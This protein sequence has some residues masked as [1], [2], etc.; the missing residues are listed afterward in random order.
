MSSGSSYQSYSP[1]S[2]IFEIDKIKSIRECLFQYRRNSRLFLK[3]IKRYQP[4]GVTLVD[5]SAMITTTHFSKIFGKSA[6]RYFKLLK[7]AKYAVSREGKVLLTDKFKN[8]ESEEFSLELRPVLEKKIHAVLQGLLWREVELRSIEGCIHICELF[9][10]I[11]A[12]RKKEIVKENTVGFRVGNII[13]YVDFFSKPTFE[14]IELIQL[15]LHLLHQEKMQN[16]FN[17]ISSFSTEK[18]LWYK[19]SDKKS[20]FF[21][22]LSN[23]IIDSVGILDLSE[24]QVQ[25]SSGSGD[26]A[27]ATGTL[28]SQFSHTGVSDKT[29]YSLTYEL[30]TAINDKFEYAFRDIQVMTNRE[31]GEAVI[32]NLYFKSRT[33]GNVNPADNSLINRF[34]KY[35]SESTGKLIDSIVPIIQMERT[36]STLSWRQFFDKL[37]VH[38]LNHGENIDRILNDSSRVLKQFFHVEKVVFYSDDTEI[39][40]MLEIYRSFE[41][42]RESYYSYTCEMINRDSLIQE[43]MIP[44]QLK[45]DSKEKYYLYVKLPVLY[46]DN[47]IRSEATDKK[48]DTVFYL[49]GTGIYEKVR[50]E[51][52]KLD[53]AMWDDL[54][55]FLITNCFSY[56]PSTFLININ[57][58]WPLSLPNHKDNPM[59]KLASRVLADYSIFFDLLGTVNSNLESGISNMRGSRDRLTGLY[60]RQTFNMYLGNFFEKPG[61]G[62]GL[63]FLDMDDF[64]IYNDSI[65]HCFGDKLLIRLASSLLKASA[66]LEEKSLSARFGGDEFSFAIHD[67]NAAGFESIA[68]RIFASITQEPIPVD[69]YLENRPEG[70]GFEVN[71]IAFLHRLIRPDVGG[72]QET[73]SEFVESEGVSPRNHI[74]NIY[75]HY[76]KML[77]EDAHLDM[78]TLL[79]SG[80]LKADKEKEIITELTDIIKSKLLNN[81]IFPAIDEEMEMVVSR[82]VALQ[83]EDKTTDVIREDIMGQIGKKSLLRNIHLRVSTG[84]AHTSEDRLRSVASLYKMADSRAYFAKQNGRNCL[85][86]INSQKLL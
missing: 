73:V 82:F 84:L 32:L 23:F 76:Q 10:Q 74:I 86:G 21:D 11:T 69:L 43:N 31:T 30:K 38:S 53:L 70:S 22:V 51:S 80:T 24:C 16:H 25:L 29:L 18:S 83:L 41:R 54:P 33:P 37:R 27:F 68:C 52:K 66:I 50:D 14:L 46:P 28:V 17:I 44:I 9:G 64:K 20:A 60:N 4:K 78:T 61:T 81:H 1:E 3:E 6:A 7:R 63:M 36:E 26:F 55:F 15:K 19:N 13:Y 8:T 56:S 45:D 79:D 2:L 49:Q 71:L 67:I 75:V 40:K 42:N 57:K 65:S 47:I 34:V 35:I 72:R 48:N 62:F 5:P 85:F 12:D 59:V 77:K 58:K 39:I